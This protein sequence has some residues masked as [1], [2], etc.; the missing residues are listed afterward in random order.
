MKKEAKVYLRHILKAVNKIESYIKDTDFKTFNSDEMRHDAV[1]RQL[2]II[3]EAI[4]R[5]SDEFVKENPDFPVK[6]AKSMR[7]FLI[8]GYDDVDLK[9]VWKTVREDIPLLKQ[10]IADL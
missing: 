1:I 5:L 4:N 2:E 6:E 8:H 9:V 10:N 3:G 7:N